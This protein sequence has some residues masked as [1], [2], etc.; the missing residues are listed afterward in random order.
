[1]KKFSTACFCRGM[2]KHKHC[3]NCGKWHLGDTK[4][5]DRCGGHLKLKDYFQF[6]EFAEAGLERLGY[7]KRRSV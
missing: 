1:M 2:Q 4:T 5:C 6:H 3:R 7:S